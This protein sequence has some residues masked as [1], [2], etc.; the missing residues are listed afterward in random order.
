M[1]KAEFNGPGKSPPSGNL[2]KSLKLCLKHASN[3][4]TLLGFDDTWVVLIEYLPQLQA[5]AQIPTEHDGS[6]SDFSNRILRIQ[7][8]KLLLDAPR[9][10]E[11]TIL[12]ELMHIV[13]LPYVRLANRIG[14]MLAGNHRN[15]KHHPLYRELIDRE[16]EM[17]T[18]L[19]YGCLALKGQK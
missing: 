6:S 9:D 11:G 15:W 8:S 10:I 12:H 13:V 19:E 5:R 14:V 16:E 2:E 1:A 7:V 18:M 17:V 3:Y 4:A